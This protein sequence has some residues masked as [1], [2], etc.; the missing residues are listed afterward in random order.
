ML[1][2]ENVKLIIITPEQAEVVSEIAFPL[3]AEVYAD[4]P[5]EI[6]DAFLQKTQTPENIRE[7]MRS[8]TV[9]M[10]IMYGGERAG[11]LAYETDAEGM[12]LSKLY[13]LK[14]FRGKGI[15]AFCL[16]YVED[17]AREKG[18]GTVR[19]EVNE[20]NPQAREFYRSHGY[21]HAGRIDYMRIV[22][23]KTL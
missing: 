5:K 2:S 23:R 21:S 14:G 13:L 12:R 4:T 1:P 22:M 8:G 20:T 16:G 6:V 19:L 15:G 9:Y 17:I 10:F 18:I 7:Q 3:F 11:Y